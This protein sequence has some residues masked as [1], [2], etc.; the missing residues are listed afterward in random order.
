MGKMKTTA[1]CL[2]APRLPCRRRRPGVL[3]LPNGAHALFGSS[4]PGA[5]AVLFS[6]L[7][8]SSSSQ[9]RPELHQGPSRAS[10]P[11]LKQFR[12]ELEI[13]ELLASS[14][15]VQ[16]DLRSSPPRNSPPSD[17]GP[18]AMHILID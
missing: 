4:F 3:P 14:A 6:P 5:D 2:V 7:L 13:F 1:S 17:V 18:G 9:A 11:G 10:Y 8:G 16:A 15:R 12:A